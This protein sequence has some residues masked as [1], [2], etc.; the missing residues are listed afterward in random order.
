MVCRECGAYNEDHLEYC[1]VCAAPLHEEP[2]SKA[3]YVA[4]AAAEPVPAP[5]SAP[6]QGDVERSS[7]G[8][9]RAPRWPQPNFDMNAV[10]ELEQP[11][12]TPGYQSPA[13]SQPNVSPEFHQPDYGAPSYRNPSYGQQ[14]AYQPE[15]YSGR[16]EDGYVQPDGQGYSAPQYPSQGYEQ[17]YQ[18][19]SSF[20]GAN[21]FEPQ[22]MYHNDAPPVEPIASVGGYEDGMGYQGGF[23]RAPQRAAVY[24]MDDQE[25]ASFAPPRK[26]RP[27]PTVTHPAGKSK[28]RGKRGGGNKNLLFFGAIGLLVVLILVFGVIIINNNYGSIGNFFS[29]VFG[30][31]PVIKDPETRE[32]LNEAG[33]ECYIVTIHAQPGNTV[34]TRVG[35]QE[36]SGTVGSKRYLDVTIPKTLLVPTEPVDGA[37]A[38]LAPEVQVITQDGEVIDLE[39]PPFTVAVPALNLN[40]TQP[41]GGSVTVSNGIVHFEGTVDDSSVEVLVEG[42]A[43]TV[44]ADGTFSGDYT[45]PDLGIYTLTLEARKAGY[46]IA[47]QTV[48]VDYTQAQANVEFDLSTLRAGADGVAT[49]KGT[50]DPGATVTVSGPSG[51]TLGTPNVNAATGIFSFTAQFAAEKGH[52]E[53]EVTVTK[54]GVSGTIPVVVERAPDYATYTSSVYA[55]AYSRM[56]N[57][58]GH[59]AAYK[60][61]GTVVE[62]LQADPYVIAVLET[63]DGKLV[64]EYHNPKYPITEGMKINVFGDYEGMDE[65]QGLPKVYGWFYTDQ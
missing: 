29:T 31:N 46:Q 22:P 48:Q 17:Q 6:A 1:K 5:P 18:P 16:P 64:F 14:P 42:T 34:K 3:Q 45:L 20:R 19:A 65:S 21:R 62:V 13:Y 15:D 10:D 12:D 47:R 27:A 24:S 30:G 58:T 7:W 25:D 51:V 49:V 63:T 37:T 52:Y 59:T 44:N 8:F 50:T 57:E 33:Q 28:N 43:L 61:P 32:G 26:K 60:C 9:V 2:A 23:G 38:D 55:L 36:I 11:Q 56:I 40:V 35:D 53:L 39:I 4:P 41:Q 54:D